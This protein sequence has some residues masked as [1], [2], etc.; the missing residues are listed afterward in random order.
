ML[1]VAA[2]YAKFSLNGLKGDD[3]DAI[4]AIADIFK[5]TFLAIFNIP[6]LSADT[7]SITQIIYVLLSSFILSILELAINIGSFTGL[8]ISAVYVFF[9]SI[10]KFNV[11]RSFGDN[12]VLFYIYLGFSAAASGILLIKNI[13]HVTIFIIIIAEI[14]FFV[15]G[16]TPKKTFTDFIQD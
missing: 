4:K 12:K 8:V 1:T 11:T 7:P 6:G 9:L 2:L 3:D 10:V 5:E 15:V 16:K 14:I 13:L